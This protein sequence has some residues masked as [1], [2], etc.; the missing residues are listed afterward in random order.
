MTITRTLAI[1]GW[2]VALSC[3]IGAIVVRIAVPAPF[4]PVTFGFGDTAMLAFLVMAMSWASVGAY[5]AIKR[6]ENA[7]GRVMVVSGAGY[8]LSMLAL[9][10]TFAFAADGTSRGRATASP[11]DGASRKRSID[12]FTG[13][14]LTPIKRWR[15]SPTGFGWRSTWTRSRRGWGW[16]SDRPSP[17]GP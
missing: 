14:A 1:A 15:R 2:V 12:D 5:L 3:T 4:L 9:A 17:R 13:P 7:I 6:P 16:A 10:L 8:A 11:S